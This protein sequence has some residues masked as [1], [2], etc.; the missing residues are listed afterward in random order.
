[1]PKQQ[2][3]IQGF[4]AYHGNKQDIFNFIPFHFVNMLEFSNS[5]SFKSL[6]N[7]LRAY[8]LQQQTPN[9]KVELE[10]PRLKLEV[11]KI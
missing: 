5:V 9:I 10:D 8:G 3:Q 11:I 1:L 7:F 2:H 4:W 6:T